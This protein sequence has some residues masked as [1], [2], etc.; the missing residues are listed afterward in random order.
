MGPGEVAQRLGQDRLGVVVGRAK[1]NDALDPGI[2]DEAFELARRIKQ[3][4][5]TLQE[6]AA[7]VGQHHLPAGP[8]EERAVHQRFQPF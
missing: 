8:N 2:V 7:A 5:G 3:F 4:V 1:P 6:R